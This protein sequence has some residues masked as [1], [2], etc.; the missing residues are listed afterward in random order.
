MTW[1][2]EEGSAMGPLFG[3]GESDVGAEGD[4]AEAGGGA[5]ATAAY[6]E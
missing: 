1:P 6:D 5:L 3:V 2:L 4:H